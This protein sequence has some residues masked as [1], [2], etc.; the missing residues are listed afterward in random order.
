MMPL[1]DM[2]LLCEHQRLRDAIGFLGPRL[3]GKAEH[4]G[5][6]A[7]IENRIRGP[8]RWCRKI[9]GGNWR[10]ARRTP[11]DRRL[12]GHDAARKGMPRRRAA[13]A[14]VICAPDILVSRKARCDGE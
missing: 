13:A 10:H 6:L 1:R 8:L 2:T 4:A 12:R 9:P 14:I 11:G 5:E 3:P 7:A